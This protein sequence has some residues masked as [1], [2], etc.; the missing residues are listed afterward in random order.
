MFMNAP[1]QA[2]E[3]GMMGGRELLGGLFMRAMVVESDT[4]SALELSEALE[5]A[6]FNIVGPARSSGEAMLLAQVEAPDVVVMGLNLEASGA[7][8]RLADKFERDF[9]MPAVLTSRTDDPQTRMHCRQ[10]VEVALRR[11]RR[12]V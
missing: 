1:P 5:I 12:R 3:G 4:L 2:P 8:R 10:V 7:G 6:G 11:R 9:K